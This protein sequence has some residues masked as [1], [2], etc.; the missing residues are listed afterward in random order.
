MKIQLL[1][2]VAILFAAGALAGNEK[3]VVKNYE[4]TLKMG[5]VTIGGETAGAM[6]KTKE[7]TKYELDFGKDD[8]LAKLAESLDG[9]VVCVTG[10]LQI[11]TGTEIKE[12]QVIAVISLKEAGVVR[13]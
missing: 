3:G 12:R 9:K 4:G 11:R 13:P 5:I 1:S 2:L 7:G 8:E 10:K 6:L